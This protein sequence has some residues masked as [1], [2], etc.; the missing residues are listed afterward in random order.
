[1]SKRPYTQRSTGKNHASP[2]EHVGGPGKWPDG[3]DRDGVRNSSQDR[4]P[5]GK[6]VNN[7]YRGT[8]YPGRK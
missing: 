3:Q 2:S 6:Q 4:F 8:P 5:S 7:S 1:M